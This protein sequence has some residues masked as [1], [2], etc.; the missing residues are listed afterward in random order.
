MPVVYEILSDLVVFTASGRVT[1]DD[2]SLAFEKAIADTRFIRGSKIL[3][4]DIE[5][6][7]EPSTID[8]KKVAE[9]LNSF[10]GHF[11]RRIA[12]VVHKPE[13]IGAGKLIQKA[14]EEFGIEY[15]VFSDPGEAKE[16]LYPGGF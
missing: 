7:L 8:P 13:S 15:E 4:Y 14:C 9:N 16:W 12:V 10:M 11:D 6:A 1:G 5:S 3:T 2:F